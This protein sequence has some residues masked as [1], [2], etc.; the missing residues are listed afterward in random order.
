MPKLKKLNTQRL[1]PLYVL[2]TVSAIG[3]LAMNMFIP[4]MPGLVNAFATD[5]ATAQL[6]LT[7]YLVAVAVAQLIIGPLS[8]RFGRRPVLLVGLVLFAV[9]TSVCALAGSV[10]ALLVGRVV[11][12]A[13]GCAGLVLGRAIVRDVFDANRAA[14][15]IGYITMAMV[16]AP[17]VGPAI[18]GVLDDRFGWR[19]GFI[20]LGVLAVP[21]LA[22]ASARMHETNP[23]RRAG[24]LLAIL[25]GAGS[26]LR[27]PLFWG[28]TAIMSF[29]TGVFFAFVAGAP[30]AVVNLMQR[31]ATDYGLYFMLVALAY[32]AGNFY[33]G[34]RATALGPRRLM[35]RGFNVSLL[36]VLGLL[37]S[38]ALG[39]M[40]PLVLFAPMAVSA[41]GHGLILPGAMASVVSVRPELAGAASGLSGSLQIAFGALT[42]VLVAVMQSDSMWPMVSLMTAWG[43]GC[44]LALAATRR[45]EAPV[46]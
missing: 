6:T 21:V 11:Q 8:D 22:L 7:L 17:M 31:P 27:V 4:S 28:Y 25:R 41:L 43:L 39:P 26:L 46:P 19:A 45:A 5:Y 36:G 1:P 40:H 32:M 35:L 2:V 44:G 30:Y 42:T 20:V 12:A 13:G 23:H 18:G 14:S 15:A 9:G 16:V 37:L 3:P 34:R 29:T 10:A 33:S 38:T 24:G